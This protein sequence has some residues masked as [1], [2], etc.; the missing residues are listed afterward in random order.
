M[1]R[2]KM[3][4]RIGYQ[5]LSDT[6]DAGYVTPTGLWRNNQ[7]VTKDFFDT[8]IAWACEGRCGE[9]EI[10]EGVVREFYGGNYM[11]QVKVQWMPR[12]DSKGN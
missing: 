5:P 1:V 8:I 2:P 10:G 9:D 6:V 11:V 3:K 7:E 4:M 12:D